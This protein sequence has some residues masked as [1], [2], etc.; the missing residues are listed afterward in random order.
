MH[1][2]NTTFAYD[3]EF[4]EHM[5]VEWAVSEDI[6][7]YLF[8]VR[9]EKFLSKKGK[10]Y[11]LE[12]FEKWDLEHLKQLDEDFDDYPDNDGLEDIIGDEGK[13]NLNNDD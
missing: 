6:F 1:C 3:N 11:L 9:A 5:K 13:Q 10:K 8:D 2:G 4:K 7:D 12:L